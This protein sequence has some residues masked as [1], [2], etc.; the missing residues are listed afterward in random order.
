[1]TFS[2]K[3]VV[4]IGMAVA[5]AFAAHG[6]TAMANILPSN[7]PFAANSVGS[8]TFGYSGNSIVCTSATVSG[9]TPAFGVSALSADVAYRN[10]TIRGAVA[11][12]ATCRGRMT[13][14]ITAFTFPSATGT[15]ALDNGFDCTFDVPSIRC[16][17]SILGP[18]PNVGV[19]DYTNTSQVLGITLNGL[20][21]TDTGGDCSGN[22]VGRTRSGTA[23]Y[24]SRDLMGSRV[25]MS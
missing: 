17:I 9:T 25:M 22:T 10:C 19:F 20:S 1:M 8:A 14:R 21:A 12:T 5:G 4:L 7:T 6:T 16:R 15:V 18:Q 11:V 23:I 24:T 3:R 2:I 13:L